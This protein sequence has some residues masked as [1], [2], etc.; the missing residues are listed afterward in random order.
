MT[1]FIELIQESHSFFLSYR[2]NLPSSFNGIILN[3][4][5]YCTYLPVSV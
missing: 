5:V 1:T 2:A 3:I 4:F